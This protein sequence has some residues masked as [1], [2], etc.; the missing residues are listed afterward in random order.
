MHPVQPGDELAGRYR[1]RGIIGRGGMGI[2]WLALDEYLDR[3]VAIK[4][5]V[6]PLGL[7]EQDWSAIRRRC[8][9]EARTAARLTHHNIVG[10]H[11]VIEHDGRPWI[12]MQYVPYPSLHE[13]IRDRGPLPAGPA[14]QAGLQVLSALRA[15]HAA[16]VMHRDVKPANVLL[17]PEGKVVLAD[18]GLAVLDTGPGMT[19]TGQVVGSPAYMAPERARGERATPA[20]DLWSLGATLYAAAE[21][22][23]PF[24]R[25][26]TVAVLTA[27]VT[28]DP[29][30]PVQAGPLWPVISGLMRKDPNARLSADQA[31]T[32]LLEV[33]HRATT[34]TVPSPVAV[35][36]PAAAALVVSATRP[37]AGAA[38]DRCS[39]DHR[40]WW[41][42]TGWLGGGAA[43]VV[44]AAAIA[45][46]AMLVP[47]SSGGQ[48]AKQPPRPA[49]SAVGV[50]TA[51]ARSVSTSPHHGTAHRSASRTPHPGTTQHPVSATPPDAKRRP[52]GHRKHHKHGEGGSNSR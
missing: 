32:L 25:T 15:A 31:E 1:L 22:R 8:L 44:T 42:S 3:E 6:R 28:E 35:S 51:P 19:V 5:A 23:A 34:A 33:S 38:L 48:Q 41:R 27:L 30:Q 43:A 24:Q 39:R 16:G 45:L 17:G 4:E 9:R 7:D 21:G 26:S 11:D 2:V 10:V 52:R 50:R 46:I 37:D 18:F 29:D 47:E 36:D 40:A 12:V 49:A 14:A 13:V 20:A